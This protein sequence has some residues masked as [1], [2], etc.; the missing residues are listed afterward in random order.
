[1]QL[2]YIVGQRKGGNIE[3]VDRNM[4]GLTRLAPRLLDFDIQAGPDFP[5]RGKREIQILV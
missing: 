2:A 4:H 3:S 5:V 1:M